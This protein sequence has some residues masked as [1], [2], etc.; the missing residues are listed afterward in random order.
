[1]TDISIRKYLSLQYDKRSLTLL[2]LLDF[3][4]T[5]HSY[6]KRNI[7][8]INKQWNKQTNMQTKA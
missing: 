1:M 4:A 7:F 6:I 2:F 5:N 8:F 3:V